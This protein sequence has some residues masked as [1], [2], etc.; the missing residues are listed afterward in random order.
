[1]K[2]ILVRAAN[3]IIVEYLAFKRL[4]T[5]SSLGQLNFIIDYINDKFIYHFIIEA[6]DATLIFLLQKLLANFLVFGGLTQSTFSLN[7]LKNSLYERMWKA[8]ESHLF[9]VVVY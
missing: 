8:T 5:G 9:C 1:M 3:S 7:I 4:F 2:F 6:V